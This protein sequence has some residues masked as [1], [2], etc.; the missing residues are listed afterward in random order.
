MS[1]KRGTRNAERRTQNAEQNDVTQRRKDAKTQRSEWITRRIARRRYP[2]FLLILVLLALPAAAGAQSLTRRSGLPSDAI[3]ALA[4]Q[5]GALWV[6]S[7]AGLGRW[8]AARGATRTVEFPLTEHHILALTTHEGALWVGTMDGVA[9]LTGNS[10]QTW[11]QGDAGLA[12]DWVTSLAPHGGALVAGSYGGG[13]L[14]WGGEQWEP[15]GTNAPR[16]IT[17]L[18]SE[19]ERLWAGT[20]RGLWRL[21][22]G[23]WQP[24]P[25]PIPS[26]GITALQISGNN[27]LWVGSDAG[28]FHRRADGAWERVL[29]EPITALGGD[30]D[31]VLAAT[32]AGALYSMGDEQRTYAA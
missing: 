30:G 9:Q 7:I 11:Q 28:L 29:A 19:G 10:W 8:D 1:E 17:A 3:T 32:E 12:S 4:W 21:E 6:G 22:G 13:V 20:P 2:W 24:E 23:A 27:A 18:A 15:V 16:Q 26:V 5:D 25:L 14:R 31:Q